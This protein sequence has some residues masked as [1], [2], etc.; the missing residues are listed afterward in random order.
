MKPRPRMAENRIAAILSDISE[1]IGLPGV[2]RIP[3]TGERGP[4]I[5]WN[6][7]ELVVDVK[8]RLQVPNLAFSNNMFLITPTLVS[9]PIGRL[10]DVISEPVKN[11]RTG[12]IMIY[13]WY[14]HMDQ[15]R[16]EQLPSGITALVLHKPRMQYKKSSL[17]ISIYDKEKLHARIKRDHHLDNQH[18]NGNAT[19]GNTGE[20]AERSTDSSGQGSIGSGS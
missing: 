9:M 6:K 4:D 11:V 20:P 5:S 13:R 7:L 8:S 3:V 17:I 19:D 16:Q 1:Q 12:S 10:L 14:N 18:T 15:W 2:H